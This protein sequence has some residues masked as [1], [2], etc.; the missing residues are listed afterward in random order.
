MYLPWNRQQKLK[1]D[2]NDFDRTYERDMRQRVEAQGWQL[3][4]WTQ[5]L[6]KEE[7]ADLW[8]QALDHA[9]RPTQIVD[10]MR[11]V[12]VCKY[13]GVYVQYD[14]V[15]H[16]NIDQLL[17]SRG[18]GLRL[19]TE[20]VLTPEQCQEAARKY[21]IRQGVP[22][23]PLRV[24]NQVFAAARPDHP[25]VVRCRDTILH[26]MKTHQPRDDYELLHSGA[27]S[28]I[29]TLYD[30]YGKHD[31]T[32]EMVRERNTK[33]AFTVSSRGSWRTDAVQLR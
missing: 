7:F 3:K 1:P 26:R 4:M 32:I 16:C 17:P 12:V 18:R 31:S 2:Y 5:P 27:T 15:I 6:L 22:E 19:F 30:V 9:V 28:L 11:W 10:L 21:P 8:S 14:S 24:M 23:E 33:R 20:R 25:F 13:G 29:S